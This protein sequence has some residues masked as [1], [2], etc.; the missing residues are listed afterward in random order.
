[1]Q[2]K[3]ES[4]HFAFFQMQIPSRRRQSIRPHYQG[5]NSKQDWRRKG[6]DQRVVIS[7]RVRSLVLKTEDANGRL[8]A[9]SVGE[10]TKHRDKHC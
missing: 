10:T 3:K 1:M 7:T 4:E 6:A 8:S 2:L 5:K 9:A